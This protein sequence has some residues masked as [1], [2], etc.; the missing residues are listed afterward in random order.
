M[1]RGG[2][3]LLVWLF[4][5]ACNHSHRTFLA[6]ESSAAKKP[7]QSLPQDF[8]ASEDWQKEEACCAKE[9]VCSTASSYLERRGAFAPGATSG[10]DVVVV[11]A[12]SHTEFEPGRALQSMWPA[13]VTDL[14]TREIKKEISKQQEERQE[15]QANLERRLKEGGGRKDPFGVSWK[16]SMDGFHAT[17]ESPQPFAS[18]EYKGGDRAAT[19]CSSNSTATPFESSSR[20]CQGNGGIAF[21]G[22]RDEGL[23]TLPWIESR[24]GTSTYRPPHPHG[25]IGE[26]GEGETDLQRSYSWALEQKAQTRSKTGHCSWEDQRAGQRV[27]RLRGWDYKAYQGPCRSLQTMSGRSLAKLCCSQSGTGY[28][29]SGDECSF[30]PNAGEPGERDG[31]SRSNQ[32]YR[33]AGGHAKGHECG[34]SAQ[35]RHRSTSFECSRGGS[36]S[37]GERG[38]RDGDGAHSRWE[39]KAQRSEDFCGFYFANESGQSDLEAESQ[40][41]HIVKGHA[42]PTWVSWSLHAGRLHSSLVP[43]LCDEPEAAWN[44]RVRRHVSFSQRVEMIAWDEETYHENLEITVAIDEFHSLMRTL[45]NLHGQFATWQGFQLVM[46]RIGLQSHV[47][48]FDTLTDS[49]LVHRPVSGDLDENKFDSSTTVDSALTL[50]P[51]NF[52]SADLW[53]SS[54]DAKND[55]GTLRRV[56]VVTWYVNPRTLPAC[57]QSRKV[58]ITNVQDENQ[59]IAA[60]RRTWNDIVTPGPI[61]WHDVQIPEDFGHSRQHIILSQELRMDQQVSLFSYAGFPILDRVRA[62]VFQANDYAYDILQKLSI[63]RVCEA[64]DVKCLLSGLGNWQHVRFETWSRVNIVPPILIEVKAMVME[65]MESSS[66]REDSADSDSD[67]ESTTASTANHDLESTSTED[68]VSSLMEGIS[69]TLR[70]QPNIPNVQALWLEYQGENAGGINDDVEMEEDV[71]VINFE[72]VQRDLRTAAAN[73]DAQSFVVISYGVGLVSLGRR[74]FEMSLIDRVNWIWSD[75]GAFAPLH[76]ITV[77]PQPLINVGRPYMVIIVEVAYTP[78]DDPLRA[79]PILVQETGSAD[80]TASPAI[81]AAK[82]ERRQSAT[83]LLTSLGRGSQVV[84]YGVRDVRVTLRNIHM[85]QDQLTQVE[86]GDLCVILFGSIPAHVDNAEGLLDRAVPMFVDLRNVVDHFDLL[87]IEICCHGISPQNRPLGDRSIWV[88]YREMLDSSWIDTAKRLWPFHIDVSQLTY[89]SRDDVIMQEDES[90]VCIFHF[91]LS[92]RNEDN[93]VPIMVRQAIHAHND[94]ARH[95]EAWAINVRY[96]IPPSLLRQHLTHPRFWTRMPRRPHMR[97]HVASEVLQAGELIDMVLYTHTRT[98]ILAI[99]TEYVTHEDDLEEEQVSH[100]QTLQAIDQ[101]GDSSVSFLQTAL[102]SHQSIRPFREVCDAIMCSSGHAMDDCSSEPE[103]N[104]NLRRKESASNIG[105]SEA[106]HVHVVTQRSDSHYVQMQEDIRSLQTTIDVLTQA[107]WK[108]LN[109][110]FELIENNHPMARAALDIV[111][112]AHAHHGTFHIFTDGSA[113]NGTA[114]W[115]FV[116]IAEQICAGHRAFYRVGYTGDLLQADIGEF[117]ATSMDAEATAII[118]AAE[119]MLARHFPDGIRVEMH[120]HFDCTAAGYGS[121]GAQKAA[122]QW[123]NIGTRQQDARLLISLV[124]RRLGL[125][126]HHIHAHQGQP[127]NECADAIASWIR[128]GGVCENRPVLRSGS[129]LSHGFKHWAWL[130]IRPTVEMPDLETILTRVNVNPITSQ[131]DTSFNTKCPGKKPK[132]FSNVKIATVN[133]GTLAYG[134]EKSG[135]PTSLRAKEI[136]QQM[137][138]E[139]YDVVAVQETRAKHDQTWTDGPYIRLISAGNKGQGGVELWFH[140]YLLSQKLGVQINEQDFTVWHND[141]RV[142]AVHFDLDPVGVDIFCCYAPQSGKPDQEILEWWQYLEKIVAERPWQSPIW[143]LGDLNCKIGS[144]SEFRPHRRLNARS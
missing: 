144:V 62:V 99:L 69:P 18:R 134:K 118:A 120:L 122:N 98:N 78:L 44:K 103:D 119:Y 107:D 28:T 12:M 37:G 86:D 102:R 60:C 42:V 113:K 131:P 45:W 115:S 38:R 41:R 50:D 64:V 97:R 20:A 124:Q 140:E 5:A 105:L 68:D 109:T 24:K 93:E 79:A 52:R 9:A 138:D 39:G 40:S 71:I 27:G 26:A 72:D 136:M 14:A 92:Y 129:L 89:V 112:A 94:D 114:A 127:W 23:G 141:S 17:V 66:D 133:V 57:C 63:L 85:M 116:V 54:V 15:G 49:E 32:F 25:S 8:E 13:L 3:A 31:S 35:H 88:T 100:M 130:Q 108:G 111:P 11:Q 110:D 67:C 83:S 137:H 95:A 51:L 104:S 74:D 142:L 81:Y 91:I 10:C 90:A 58:E 70:F 16:S 22:R 21:D 143:L 121:V 125:E 76:I 19:S 84:P 46:G 106:D 73:N 2:L 53:D 77:S 55:L 139:Q 30:L 80:I 135:M 123:Y 126:A 36:H 59:F 101:D 117:E 29:P 1:V 75:H 61:A 128:E 48:D 96:D 43:M 34:N 33:A 87:R 6:S 65:G 56:F 4:I 47:V 132:Q 7:C 82:T